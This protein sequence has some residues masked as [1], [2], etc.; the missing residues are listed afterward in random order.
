VLR[1]LDTNILLRYLVGDNSEQA[2]RSLNLLLRVENGEEKVFTSSLVIFDTVFKLQKFYKVPRHVIA[3][4][5]LNIISLRNLQLAN[6]DI[7]YH[8]FNLY[9]STNIS[10]ADAF[11]AAYAINLEHPTVYSWDTDFDK[12]EGITRI[13]PE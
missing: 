10:F 3:E 8:A 13:E 12:I 2:Q 4:Q 1:F 7:Y 9:A 11:N 5:M 6:K